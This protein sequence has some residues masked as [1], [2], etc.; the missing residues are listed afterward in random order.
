MNGKPA[1]GRR[2]QD[3]RG[4][5]ERGVFMALYRSREQRHR[6]ALALFILL[7]KHGLRGVLFT[8]PLYAVAAAALQS[9]GIRLLVLL[10]LTLPGLGVSSYILGKG[11]KDDYGHYVRDVLLEKGYARRLASA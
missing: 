10:A 11:V 3:I 1:S 8:W 4:E 6:R 7:V 2:L 5:L 9:P